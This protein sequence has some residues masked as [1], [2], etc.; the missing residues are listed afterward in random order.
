MFSGDANID[1]GVAGMST[2]KAIYQEET[3]KEA[4][5]GLWTVA[6]EVTKLEGLLKREGFTLAP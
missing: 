2:L 6:Q 1:S 5:K 4:N 3:S